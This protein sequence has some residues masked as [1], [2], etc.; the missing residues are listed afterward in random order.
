MAI[1]VVVLVARGTMCK[2]QCVRYMI[3]GDT[4][5]AIQCV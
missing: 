3:V 4:M 2:I 5:C 1:V